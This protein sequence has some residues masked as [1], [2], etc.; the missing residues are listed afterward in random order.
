MDV[1]LGDPSKPS[2]K[3][4]KNVKDKPKSNSLKGGKPCD[5]QDDEE[6]CSNRSVTFSQKSALEAHLSSHII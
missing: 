4:K 1:P 3:I 6:E 2:N 5:N